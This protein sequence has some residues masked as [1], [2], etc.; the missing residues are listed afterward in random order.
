M[1]MSDLVYVGFEAQYVRKGTSVTNIE[2]LD[3]NHAEL[4]A[5]SGID[6][7]YDY[8]EFPVLGK[9]KFGGEKVKGA[10]FAGV[11]IGLNTSAV[12]VYRHENGTRSH[13]FSDDI[14]GIDI[15]LDIGAGVEYRVGDGMTLTGDLRY[16]YGVY[17][18][19]DAVGAFGDESWKSRDIKL[20]AGVMFD[21]WKSSRR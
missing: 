8:I 10:L 2:Y 13:D 21:I 20:S 15:G 17:D 5:V 4:G 11:D 16:S 1:K 19:D 18:I 6:F 12:G 7:R 3:A 9:L 14:S